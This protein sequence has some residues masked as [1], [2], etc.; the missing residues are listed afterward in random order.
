[1]NLKDIKWPAVVLISVVVVATIAA[2]TVLT[3]LGAGTAALLSFGI[4]TL[5]GL[6]V[7][8]GQQSSIRDNVNGNTGRMLTMIEKQTEMLAR[9][10]PLQQPD[11][12]PTQQ[13]ADTTHQ[14]GLT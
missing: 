5:M 13:P 14:G 12:R 1:M 7:M 6:G 10:Q 2:V 4:A 3:W 9:M 8:A 11:E